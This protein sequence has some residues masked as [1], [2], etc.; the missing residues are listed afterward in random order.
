MQMLM[1][2]VL[3]VVQAPVSP[4]ANDAT[5]FAKS[6]EFER[7]GSY[8]DAID[9]LKNV[10]RKSTYLHE[11]RLGWL[12]YLNGDYFNSRQH[13]QIA[14]RTAPKSLEPRLGI[15][16]PILAQG[17]YD[18]VVTTAHSI[19]AQDANNYTAA[20]RLAF[21]LRMQAKH[22]PARELLSEML[23]LYP[24]DKSLL[25]EQLLNSV[26]LQ[27][28]DV[29]ELCDRILA[30]DPTNTYALQYAPTSGKR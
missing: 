4:G 5:A 18:E 19:L 15:L 30:I 24:T 12:Y 22:R 13:Y 10:N 25:L 2:M 27:T 29:G 14:M 6:L 3:L 11:L 7:S 20:L 1:S 16:A 23:V 17:K 21:A 8:A 9:A 28:S 26:A